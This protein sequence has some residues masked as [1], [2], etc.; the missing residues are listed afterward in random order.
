[1]TNRLS[2][3]FQSG[4]KDLLS[5]Y[6]TAGYPALNDTLSVAQA[7]E[8]AGADLIEVGIP[9]SDPVADGPVIQV[10]NEKALENGMTLKLLFSQLKNLREKVQIPVLLMGY[11]NP[12]Y[13]FGL[14]EFCRQCRETGIDG[15]I[16]PDMPLWEYE[17]QWKSV[18]E[19]Y[20][21]FNIF[22][23]T[24]QTS[25]ERIRKIDSLS[26]SFIYLVSAASVTG[27]K[28][29]VSDGQLAYFERIKAMN[30]KSPTLIGFGISNRE[31][32]QG[33]CRFADGAIIGSAFIKVLENLPEGEPAVRYK[34]V[35]D[36][37]QSIK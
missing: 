32:F 6:F 11:F 13:Q 29:Q 8:D 3:L 20:G 35:H 27:A 23:V 21:L 28:S 24:P 19:N 37:I 25:E 26:S 5:V 17:T 36:F 22:L 2:A 15:L 34:A 10:S 30:L 9:F 7:L 18:L 4:R 14:E 1:M 12:V 16:I 31:T 33:A